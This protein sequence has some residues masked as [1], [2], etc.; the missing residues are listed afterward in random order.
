M[1]YGSACDVTDDHSPTEDSIIGEQNT[2]EED[3]R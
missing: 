3:G 2:T 1:G